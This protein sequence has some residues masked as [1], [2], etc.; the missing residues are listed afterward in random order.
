M[1]M[2]SVE[3]FER[4]NY[5]VSW[6]CDD[7][8]DNMHHIHNSCEFLFI[9]EGA[10]YYDIDGVSYYVQAGDILTIGAM[11]HHRRVIDKLPFKRYGLTIKPTYYKSL[12]LEDDLLQVFETREVE[13]FNQHCKAIAPEVFEELVL[14]LKMLREEQTEHHPFRS[15]MERALIAQT[16]IRLFRIFGLKRE[17]TSLTAVHAA[18]LEIK[19]YIQENYREPLNLKVLSG[20]FFLHPATISKEFHKYCAQSLNKYINSVRISAAAKL[21]ENTN[22]SIGKIA[23][24]CGFESENTFLRQ[25][26]SRMEISPTIYR[27]TFRE[28]RENKIPVTMDS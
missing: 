25:F 7:W 19:E 20:Q 27:K 12:A 28:L 2:D 16:M 4:Y 1:K 18:M 13:Y 11:Q 6:T 3:N 9:E 8:I 17:H 14:L 24:D 21:L 15:R 5:D 22:D 26:K 10:A 23:E